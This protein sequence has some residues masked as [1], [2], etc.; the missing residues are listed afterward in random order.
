[1][2]SRSARRLTATKGIYLNHP[3]GITWLAFASALAWTATA[4]DPAGSSSQTSSTSS[5][6]P[7]QPPAAAAKAE[8]PPPM[9]LHQV[10]GNGGVFSTLSAY[11]VNPPRNGEPVGRPSVG[12]GYISMGLGS[13]LMSL[14]P[15]EAAWRTIL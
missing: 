10:E 1:M 15:T 7:T 8:K 12:F 13:D 9:P 3:I 5:T 14:T 6:S 4:A 2:G 11:L